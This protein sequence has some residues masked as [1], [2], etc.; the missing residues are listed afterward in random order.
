V[1]VTF[2]PDG[3]VQSANVDQAPYQGTPVGACIAGK[4]RGIHIPPFA[5]GAVGV[6][7]S[8]TIN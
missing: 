1:K 4:F 6:G 3:T 2:N 5:G 7:K 8:F